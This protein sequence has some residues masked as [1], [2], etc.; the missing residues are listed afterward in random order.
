M[1]IHHLSQNNSVLN[2]FLGQIRNVNVH[3]DSMRFRR[4]IERIGEIMAYEMSKELHYKEVT[5]ETPL[6]VKN[7]TEISDQLVIGSILRAGLPL[8][9]GFLNY[10][11]QAENGFVSAFR[12][13]PNNDDYFEI[14][15]DYQA[16]ADF[17]DKYLLIVDPMLATGQSIVAVFNK[18]METG[19]PKAI[20]IAVVIAAP[21]G[22]A[23]LE[24]HLP[25]HCH[26]WIADL[27]EKLNEHSYIVPGL[28]DAG[29][30]AYGS[31]L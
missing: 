2:H 26:L 15:V 10:F 14:K 5:I 18:L 7:T 11:D 16:I 31:K 21:E 29:D 17:N 28:G 23:Y 24:E 19:T 13:H 1:Q 30:L 12:F 6:G 9:M 25:D 4:N 27:D 8:H 3:K 22:I 20:H